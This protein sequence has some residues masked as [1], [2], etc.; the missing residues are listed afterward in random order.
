[1][2]I[3]LRQVRILASA[4]LLGLFV[5]GASEGIALAQSS[6]SLSS[7]EAAGAATATQDA[8]AALACPAAA[9]ARAAHRHF[10]TLS[11]AQQCAPGAVV[12]DSG[13]FSLQILPTTNVIGYSQT[14]IVPVGV[15]QYEIDRLSVTDGAAGTRTVSAGGCPE[16]ST[17]NEGRWFIDEYINN[18]TRWQRWWNYC[19]GGAPYAHVLYVSPTC[20]A[21]WPYM[22]SSSTPYTYNDWGRD[23]YTEVYNIYSVY[24]FG[25][26]SESAWQ[27]MIWDGR[28]WWDFYGW[29]N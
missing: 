15:N 16:T 3:A 7:L 14:L 26:T 10:F 20:Q 28:G 9:S 25:S 23:V 5:F 27:E 22:C 18:Q 4:L 29:F 12:S 13:R 17:W 11:E 19:G 2:G 6:P 1:M 21:F 24:P 8:T